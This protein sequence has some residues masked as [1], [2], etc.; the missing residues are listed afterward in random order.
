MQKM[1]SDVAA[2]KER[3]AAKLA[4]KQ[5]VKAE[6]FKT[7]NNKDGFYQEV[8]IALNSYISNKLN[9]PV[10]ELS[11][12]NIELQLSKRSVPIE[13]IGKLLATLGDCDVARY[14]PSAVSND[15]NVVYNNTVELITK[16]EDETKA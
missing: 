15:I 16:I 8:S 6:V 4:R 14:A 11:K 13:T 10:A 7:Q 3:K 12:E 1:N 9:I 2:V 5:L